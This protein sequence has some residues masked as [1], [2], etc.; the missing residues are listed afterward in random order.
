MPNIE[1]LKPIAD[2]AN[3]YSYRL[4]VKP[5]SLRVM[6]DRKQAELIEAGAVFRTRGKSRLVNPEA[7]MSW[8]LCH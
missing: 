4:G 7:F 6:I 2:F 5:R 1:N 3:E 8:Y